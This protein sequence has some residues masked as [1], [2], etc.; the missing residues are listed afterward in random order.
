MRAA[1]DDAEILSSLIRIKKYVLQSESGASATLTGASLEDALML[2]FAKA[3]FTTGDA[4]LV[5]SGTQQHLNFLGT[6]PDD[7]DPIPVV[8]PSPFAYPT[9]T[10]VREMVGVDLGYIEEGSASF[11]G[12]STTASVGAANAAGNIWYGKP[13]IGELTASWGQRAS[14]LENIASAYGLADSRV[15]GAGTTENP[16]RLLVH[17]DNMASQTTFAYALEG[18]LNDGRVLRRYLLNP[19]PLINISTA[20]GAADNPAVWTV[21]CSYT[22]S[23]DV[24]TP[25]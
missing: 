10:I 5:G 21:G 4:V 18:L 25:S 11:A 23:L 2:P 12:S 9:G 7:T 14:S 6:I 3:G 22:H 17:P 24:I 8:I 1:A 16:Y 19:R 15:K 20:F 13:R